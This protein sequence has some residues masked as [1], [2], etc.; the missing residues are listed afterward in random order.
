MNR[1][2]VSINQLLVSI[3]FISFTDSNFFLVSTKFG[4]LND[5][6]HWELS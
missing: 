4:T 5:L 6:N 1:L 3:E 2:M